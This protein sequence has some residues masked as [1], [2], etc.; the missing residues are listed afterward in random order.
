MSGALWC[1]PGG[2]AFSER[3][4]GRQRITV[5]ELDPETGEDVTDFRDYCGYHAEQAGLRRRTTRPAGIEARGLPAAP[6]EG[7]AHWTP[8]PG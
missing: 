5:N 7:I 6:A 3:D 1:D 4:P 8:E 2:H